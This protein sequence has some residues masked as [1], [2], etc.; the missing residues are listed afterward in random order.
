[1]TD[2]ALETRVRSGER[3]TRS[4]RLAY[5]AAFAVL[6][7]EVAA[8]L[9]D[10]ALDDLRV[11]L[12]DASTEWSWSHLLA[13]AALASGAGISLLATRRRRDEARQWWSLAAFFGVL[14]ADNVTRAH[15]AVP[16]WPLIVLPA[17]AGVAIGVVRLARGTPVFE[18]AVA[19]LALLL[20]SFA[21]HV[22]GHALVHGLGWGPTTW[23]YQIK[24]A[25]K[26]GTE[27]AGWVLLVPVLARLGRQ[28]P[29][30][31]CPQAP[32]AAPGSR[33]GARAA[34]YGSARAG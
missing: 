22:L 26:E 1:M 4:D 8:H 29:A 24:V 34:P 21:I 14:L 28:P 30:A 27:L 7:I 6:M 33:P 15:E 17:L 11:R 3:R 9:L 23:G 12:L 19:G 32:A 2:V 13:T 31:P 25:L 20:A 10:F 16:H 18:T 5:L